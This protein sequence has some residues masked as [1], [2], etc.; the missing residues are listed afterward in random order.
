MKRERRPSQRGEITKQSWEVGRKMLFDM[1]HV[2]CDCEYKSTLSPTLC[3]TFISITY[4]NHLFYIN[5]HKFNVQISK[6]VEVIIKTTEA[7]NEDEVMNVMKSFI[8]FW[9]K[10]HLCHII[11]ST[12]QIVTISLTNE[13]Y[14]MPYN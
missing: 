8:F 10:K 14:N 13:N 12:F 7:I 1:W 4:I 9:Q 11:K 3:F 6:C 5:H 2:T